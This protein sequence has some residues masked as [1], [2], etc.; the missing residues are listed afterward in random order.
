M[1]IHLDRPFNYLSVVEVLVSFTWESNTSLKLVRFLICLRTHGWLVIYDLA[2]F[3]WSVVIAEVSRSN[4]HAAANS[5]APNRLLTSQNE[6]RGVLSRGNHNVV[7][8]RHLIKLHEIRI[9]LLNF[10]FNELTRV[11]AVRWVLELYVI[12]KLFVWET[13]VGRR[14]SKARRLMNWQINELLVCVLRLLAL[15]LVIRLLVDLRW[16]R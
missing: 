1:S 6:R 12:F 9:G 4:S 16:S 2:D 14:W 15:R 8:A 7:H 3:H 5:H 13:N 11:L 10:V